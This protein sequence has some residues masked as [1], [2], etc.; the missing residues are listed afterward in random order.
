[1]ASVSTGFDSEC[2][3]ETKLTLFC[4]FIL[5]YLS[6]AVFIV[7]HFTVAICFIQEKI[8]EAVSYS[9]HAEIVLS[10]SQLSRRVY[11]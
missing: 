10:R 6:L 8:K 11:M 3:A 4:T 2:L 5:Y 7:T 1:M 9:M